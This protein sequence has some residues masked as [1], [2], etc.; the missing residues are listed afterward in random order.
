M[1]DAAVVRHTMIGALAL[2][3]WSTLAVATVF[4]GPVPPFLM[5]GIAFLI[6]F[7]IGLVKWIIKGESVVAHLRQPWPAWALGVGGLFGYHALVFYALQAAPPLEA[8]LINYLW[9]LL[10]V[11]FSGFLPGHR[12]R[13]F[14]VAGT[15][16]GLAGVILLVSGGGSLSFRMDA[17]P[18]Y[19]AALAAALT[20]GCY[21]VLS[22]LMKAVPTDAVAGFCLVGSLLAFA[23][24]ALFET[25]GWPQTPLQW[26]AV[27]LLGL[28]P[29]GGAFFLW[30]LGMKRGDIQVLGALSYCTP[31]MSTML[32]IVA[33][34]G[35]LTPMVL[36]ACLMIVGGAVL[37]SK[38]MLLGRRRAAEGAAAE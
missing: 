6:A 19:L 9:P 29:A 27:I 35:S 24:H 31:L 5:V 14:H 30:D 15:L 10:I 4:A 17:V 22:R 23:C 20:W 13:W 16:A 21:S 32:L 37:A 1:R 38:D 2:L 33:G 26:G 8:N 36:V 11:L 7:V 34:S 12:L 3:L 28:G 18:G 25:G